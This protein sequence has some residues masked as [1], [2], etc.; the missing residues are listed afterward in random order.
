[1]ILERGI[2]PEVETGGFG[3]EWVEHL[4]L[5]GVPECYGRVLAGG[6]GCWGG[7]PYVV[8]PSWQVSEQGCLSHF[9]LIF[10]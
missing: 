6:I 1:M 5:R 3:G 7:R 10:S 9:G 4:V 2:H 8:N